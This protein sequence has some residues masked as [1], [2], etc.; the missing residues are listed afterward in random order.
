MSLSLPPPPLPSPLSNYKLRKGACNTQ[1]SISRTLRPAI[2]HVPLT[3]PHHSAVHTNS[4]LPTWRIIP[5]PPGANPLLSFSRTTTATVCLCRPRPSPLPPVPAAAAAASPTASTPFTSPAASTTAPVRTPRLAV[6]SLV[7]PRGR[8]TRWICCCC[9]CCRCCC[10]SWRSIPLGLTQKG[11]IVLKPRGT[12]KDGVKDGV[13]GRREG[14]PFVFR[15]LVEGRGGGRGRGAPF[16]FRATSKA[17]R[18]VGAYSFVACLSHLAIDRESLSRR[19]TVPTPNRD[20]SNIWA[21]ITLLPY[22]TKKLFAYPVPVLF[23]S[24]ATIYLL[25]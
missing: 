13:T 14:T 22:V 11:G 20:T 6:V 5:L 2:H 19:S 3:V 10:W 15:A 24:A 21:L 23:S 18:G 8:S 1:S 9:N 7:A 25:G 4:L 16:T 17:R 12:C